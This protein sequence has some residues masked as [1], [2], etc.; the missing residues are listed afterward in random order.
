MSDHPPVTEPCD[1]CDGVGVVT[2]PDWQA[3]NSAYR[4]TR[5]KLRKKAREGEDLTDEERRRLTEAEEAMP[6]GKNEEVPCGICHGSGEQPTEFGK[7]VLK[8]VADYLKVD[9]PESGYY[10]RV[11]H[12]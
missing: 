2:D 10:G 6:T 9:Q 5:Q 1:D 11:V 7:R 4:E 12:K 3:W 8:L